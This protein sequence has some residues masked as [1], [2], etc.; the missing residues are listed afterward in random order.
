MDQFLSYIN[1][2]DI[3]DSFPGIG[4]VITSVVRAVSYLH[5]RVIV[6][7]DIKPNNVLVSNFHYKNYKH[8]ELEMAFG[9]KPTVGKL[10]DFGEAKSTYTQTNALTG[11]NCTTTIHRGSIAFMVPENC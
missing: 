9:K 7:G 1:E 8:D 11:K 5:S 2:E 10:A 3:F 6:H 4:N